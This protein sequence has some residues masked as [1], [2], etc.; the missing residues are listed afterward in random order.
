MKFYDFTI[1]LENLTPPSLVA[2]YYN[3]KTHLSSTSLIFS[4]CQQT[5]AI[6][7]TYK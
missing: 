4:N 5:T 6:F 7:N 1:R 3:Y 2:E